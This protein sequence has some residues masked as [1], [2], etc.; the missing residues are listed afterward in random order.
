MA[1]QRR[2][3]LGGT[4][5]KAPAPTARTAVKPAPS[6]K[7]SSPDR[8][9]S[10]WSPVISVYD[11]WHASL[12]IDIISDYFSSKLAI[13]LSPVYQEKRGVDEAILGVKKYNYDDTIAMVF[14]LPEAITFRAQLNA[15]IEGELAEVTI[16]R[17]D[18]KRLFLLQSDVYYPEG[19]EEHEI[20]QNGLVIGIEEDATATKDG[21][22]VI[23]IS[24]QNVVSLKDGDDEYVFY[25]ELQAVLAVIDSY[26]NNIARV[27]YSSVRLLNQVSSEDK[28]SGTSAPM[29]VKRTSSGMG[30][31]NRT[32]T[33]NISTTNGDV[34]S[35]EI[36][37]AL[38]G[39]GDAP[40]NDDFPDV[41]F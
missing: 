37:N 21:K 4:S 32:L 9:K 26:I 39:P 6:T 10:Q 33:S 34:S 38:G 5:T 19:D 14:D 40:A 35:T 16:E 17:L 30:A 25:P 31:S 23:F 15:F 36:D 20:H 27:D 11:N 29:P 22:A 1:T 18:T 7:T 24:R 2:N 28:P 13:K 8:V 3:G 12:T 41:D